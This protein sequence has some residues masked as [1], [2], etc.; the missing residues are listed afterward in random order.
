MNLRLVYE[1]RGG[2]AA[3][4]W[5]PRA[6]KDKSAFFIFIVCNIFVLKLH[7]MERDERCGDGNQ[8]ARF[9]LF[10]VYLKTECWLVFNFFFFRYTR[11]E[12]STVCVRVIIILSYITCICTATRLKYFSSYHARRPKRVADRTRVC[13]VRSLVSVGAIS[14]SSEL[15][16]G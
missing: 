14:L 10:V 12:V 6:V 3:Y 5:Y 15:N 2:G 4:S 11:T 1:R 9:L 8:C 16:V 7:Y 13:L